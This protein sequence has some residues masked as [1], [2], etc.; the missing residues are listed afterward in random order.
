[1]SLVGFSSASA[2]GATTM[3]R[4]KKYGGSKALINNLNPILWIRPS[5]GQLSWEALS[6][7]QFS[8]L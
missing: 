4:E 6:S 5:F 2:G 8:C 1:M 3:K 7:G